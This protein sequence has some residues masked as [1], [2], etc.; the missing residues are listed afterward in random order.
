[1]AR[2]LSSWRL[3]FLFSIGKKTHAVSAP[4]SLCFSDSREPRFLDRSNPVCLVY[5]SYARDRCPSY[6]LFGGKVP[7]AEEFRKEWAKRMEDE[8]DHLWTASED[9]SDNERDDHSQLKKDI[10]KAKQRAKER[11]DRID[12]DDSDELYSVWSDSDGEKSLWTGD[13]GD[14]EDDVPTEAFP[15][16]RSDKHIDQ[17]F[18]FEEKPKYQTLEQALKD[19]DEPEELSPGKQ[20]RKLAV[21]NALKKLKKGPDGRYCNVWE[22]MSDMDILIG[23]FENIISG[24]EYEQLRQGGPK[25]LNMEFFKDIQAKMRD[26]NYKWSPE[27]KFKPKSKLVSRKKWQKT[28]S[29][30][31]KAQKR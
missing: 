28:Q 8:E 19:E 29:R 2:R 7:K 12:A 15:N 13:E 1:M 22:V 10:K 14:D 21:Q 4:K 18:E 23:A 25:R 20:A 6:N 24:P 3:P 9:D 30:R 31:R 17:L 16:E 27:M 11:S 26:P 5:R